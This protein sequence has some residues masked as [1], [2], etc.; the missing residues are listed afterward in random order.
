MHLRTA[1]FIYSETFPNL[2]SQIIKIFISYKIFIVFQ[3]MVFCDITIL[4]IVR[5]FSDYANMLV[6][7]VKN[8]RRFY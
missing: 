3:D 4:I 7:K 2:K 8:S 5:V 1:I 6:K